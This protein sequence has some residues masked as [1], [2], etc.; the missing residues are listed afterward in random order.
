MEQLLDG[1]TCS[2]NITQVKTPFTGHMALDLAKQKLPILA[3]ILIE[4]HA[5]YMS[6]VVVLMHIKKK[7]EICICL[8]KI[9]GFSQNVGLYH[10]SQLSKISSI[11]TVLGGQNIVSSYSIT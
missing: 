11:K 8:K 3:N 10:Q 6:V 9:G 7:A 1:D 2:F 5:E 4:K